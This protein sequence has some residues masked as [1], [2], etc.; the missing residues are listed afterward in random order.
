M[1]G[2]GRQRR[3]AAHSV[4]LLC[5]SAC[6]VA[7]SGGAVL[8]GQSASAA[9]SVLLLC[10]AACAVAASG[11]VVLVGR[12][13]RIAHERPLA[14][15]ATVNLEGAVTARLTG[16]YVE[17]QAPGR[18]DVRALAPA[19]VVALAS[20]SGAAM[21]LQ[22]RISNLAT[23]NGSTGGPVV[24]D[25]DLPAHGARELRPGS[26]GTEGPFSF[27]VCGDNHGLHGVIEQML[28]D[29]AVERPAFVVNL[30]DL[31]RD[32]ASQAEALERLL[33]HRRVASRFGGPYL[34]V[35]GNHDMSDDRGKAPSYAEV[36]GPTYCSFEYGDCLFVVLDNAHG[37]MSTKQLEWLEQALA[38]HRG[39]GPI[40]MFAH[41][42]PFD[43]RP[44]RHHA[45][46]PLIG[47]A[48]RVMELAEAA[49]VHTVFAGHLHTFAETRRGGVDYVITGGAG[50]WTHKAPPSYHYL[51][52]TVRGDDVVT[53]VRW[54]HWPVPGKGEA[55]SAGASGA[56]GTALPVLG[57][58][59]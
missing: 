57:Q 25:V 7:V 38:G 54:R 2:I 4:L 10:V 32:P 18:L 30:G 23:G 47:G 50:A 48:K 59:S 12:S 43:P 56:A 40:F 49:G 31:I 11:G 52:V 15:A 1:H 26:P 17:R 37:Y 6:A 51:K 36:F 14:A 20:G 5:V 27:F 55:G 39:S 35:L 13:R 29:A 41:Q 8:V 16:C 3:S 46:K 22:V 24:F 53:E 9:H 19:P 33:E 42:P 45:M 21:S 34:T 44:G 58:H 28:D